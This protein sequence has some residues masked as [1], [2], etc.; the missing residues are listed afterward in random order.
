MSVTAK[1]K[2]GFSSTISVS[3]QEKAPN[4]LRF[5]VASQD[6]LPSIPLI[7]A[8]PALSTMVRKSMFWESMWPTC[9]SFHSM[10]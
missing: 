2:A 9:M 6:R 5:S 4:R 7:S 10:K 8:S 1:A 3:F